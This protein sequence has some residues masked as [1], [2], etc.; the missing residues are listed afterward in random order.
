MPY[1][2]DI[3]FFM[4]FAKT[5]IFSDKQQTLAK[6]AKAM[7]HPARIAIMEL[8]AQKTMCISGDISSELPLSRSTVSQHLQELKN[9]GIIQGEVSGLNVCYCLDNE[10]INEIS[11]VFSGLFTSLL[12]VKEVV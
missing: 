8:L 11:I 2:Y 10:V 3:D 9:L 6:Y 12:E 7:S 5:T 1:I 4:T